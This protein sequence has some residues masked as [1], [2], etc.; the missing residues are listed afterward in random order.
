MADAG[1]AWDEV[2]AIGGGHPGGGTEGAGFPVGS[3]PQVSFIG[4]ASK[5]VELAGGQWGLVR[6]GPGR[7]SWKPDIVFDSVTISDRDSWGAGKGD[8]DLRVRL[9]A[10]IPVAG[11]DLRITGTG[12]ERMLAALRSAP[13][14]DV[15]LEAAPRRGLKADA[16]EWDE[17]PDGHNNTRFAAYQAIIQASGQRPAFLGNLWFMLPGSYSGEL[18]SVADM[19]V[20]FDTP[21]ARDRSGRDGQVAHNSRVLALTLSFGPTGTGLTGITRSAGADWGTSHFVRRSKRRLDRG[22]RRPPWPLHAPETLASR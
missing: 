6:Q 22:T 5:E 19:R 4:S 2:C 21:K 3:Q 13:F 10:R 1:P 14:G 8:M 17:T 9:A 16:L 12:R 18:S 7:P 15:L 20:D 11:S